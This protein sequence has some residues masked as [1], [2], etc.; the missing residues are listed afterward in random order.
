MSF[1]GT[2]S[3]KEAMEFC[4]VQDGTYEIA[5]AHNGIRIE[6]TTNNKQ[7]LVFYFK[8]N[9]PSWNHIP[10]RHVVV[11]GDYFDDGFS[12]V[13]DCFGV[14]FATIQQEISEGNF[15]QFKIGKAKFSHTQRKQVQEGPNPDGTVKTKWE[16]VKSDY[17]RIEKLIKA[18]LP[19]NAPAQ[20]QQPQQQP[21]AIVPTL[22]P[23]IQPV[24]NLNNFPE[25]KITF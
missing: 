12:R 15:S 9:S 8:I 11:E 6:N 10:Y 17:V 20:A 4:E 18:E 24:T 7:A 22:Q 2:A 14:H 16:N 5:L 1:L 13:C 21:Q 23:Q 3:Y 19:N 25:D